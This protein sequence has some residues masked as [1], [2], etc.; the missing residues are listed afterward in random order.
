[1]FSNFAIKS[2]RFVC[3]VALVA[4]D[5][6]EF[7]VE[8][9]C[10]G[11]ILKTASGTHGFGYDPLFVPDGHECSF[12]ELSAERKNAVSHRG[13]ALAEVRKVLGMPDR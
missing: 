4:P 9:S 3:A 1:M 5:G 10:P 6:R 8:G 7:T 2:L 13:R 11:R 12:A